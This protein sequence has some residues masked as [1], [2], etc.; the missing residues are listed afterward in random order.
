VHAEKAVALGPKLAIA[1]N[2]LGDVFFNESNWS[3]AEAEYRRAIALAPADARAKD[4]LSL[5]QA[6]LGRPEEAVALEQQALKLDPLR[7]ST[8]L[9]LSLYL[10]ALGRLDEAET[11][12]RHA[13]ALQTN[14]IGFHLVLTQIDILRGNAGAAL[15]DAQK[16]PA[17]WTHDTA[18]AQALQI[19]ADRPAAD[20]A[21]NS[22]IT[23][24]GDDAVVQIAETYGERKDA[25]NVF[26]WLEHARKV[27]DPGLQGLLYDPLL[28][29]YR[30]DPRFA[31]L[32]QEMNLPVPKD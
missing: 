17:G 6:G 9:D 32:C 26:K 5:L 13:I 31:K 1:H 27:K 12:I 2:A 30:H 4:T 23:K 29:P 25:D 24:Y 19:G 22:V 20:A 15:T 10:M 3:G 18:V 28:L 14:N 16:E 21:L 7:P 11:A 8:Y